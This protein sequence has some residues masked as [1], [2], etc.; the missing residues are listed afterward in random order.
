M[1]SCVTSR[2]SCSRRHAVARLVPAAGAAVGTLARCGQA[3]A[4]PLLTAVAVA[5]ALIAVALLPRAGD[6]SD[7]VAP[8]QVQARTCTFFPDASL[9]LRDAPCTSNPFGQ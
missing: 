8:A 3:A 7:S 5:A 9:L 1:T 4:P 6:P 2:P